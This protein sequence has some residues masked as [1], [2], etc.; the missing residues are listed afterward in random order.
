MKALTTLL[1]A[2][3]ALATPA[4]QG[5]GGKGKMGG[6]G[7]GRG[8]YHELTQ[9]SCKPV[10]FIFVRGTFEGEPVVRQLSER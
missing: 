5:K 7:G 8:G 4:P 2:S 6:G 1:L 9:G 10:T 3:A